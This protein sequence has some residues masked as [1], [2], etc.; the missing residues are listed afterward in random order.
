MSAAPMPTFEEALL[1]SVPARLA[2]YAWH[3]RGF[4]LPDGGSSEDWCWLSGS[5]ANRGVH[6]VVGRMN[7]TDDPMIPALDRLALMWR[8]CGAHVAL[9]WCVVCGWRLCA[10]GRSPS[11]SFRSSDWSCFGWPSRSA[12]NRTG[13]APAPA[14]APAPGTEPPP[15]LPRSARS[16][17]CC[18]RLP[19]TARHRRRQPTSLGST[20]LARR[21]VAVP[22]P[23]SK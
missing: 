16:C 14:P 8:S 10:Q 5:P 6:E 1:S 19:P 13:C 7:P 2:G 22:Q 20:R 11:R 18:G 23:L 9:M 15:P 4:S 21:C 12:P 17:L 3:C